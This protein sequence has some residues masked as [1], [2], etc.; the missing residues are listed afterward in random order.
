MCRQHVRCDES[1]GDTVNTAEVDPLDCQTS[2]ELDQACLRCIVGCLSLWNVHQDGTDRSSKDQVSKALRLE[3]LSGRLSSPESAVK[4]DPHYLRPLF[5]GVFLGW[6]VRSDAGV[7][8]Y[9]VKPSEIFIDLCDNGLDR[10]RIFDF[11]LI[12]GTPDA[13]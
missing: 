11:D 12:G 4:I 2:G 6:I 7:R 10:F 1:W 3:E 5:G 8:N 9:N 13:V